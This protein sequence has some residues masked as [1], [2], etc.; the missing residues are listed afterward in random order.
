MIRVLLSNYI[1][2]IK[3]LRLNTK[4]KPCEASDNYRF[5]V[6]L[7]NRIMSQVGC[8]P[9]W[10]ER[11]ME[12]SLPFCQSAREFDELLDRYD[13]LQQLAIAELINN[14]NCLMPCSYMKYEVQ[15]VSL[16][17]FLFFSI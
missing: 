1:Q 5:A 16:S 12:K 10:V 14:Y 9:F 11:K 2:A 4:E 6:C 17:V 7:E 3:H 15:F 13:H 8:Q